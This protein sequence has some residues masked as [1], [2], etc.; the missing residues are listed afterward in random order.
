MGATLCR[1]DIR[2]KMPNSDL[3]KRRSRIQEDLVLLYLR[4]N[5]FFVSGF[6]PHSPEIG[7]TLT[8]VDALAVRMRYCAEPEREIGPDELLDLSDRFTELA[9]CEVKSWGKQIQFNAALTDDGRALTKIL[10]WSGLFVEQEIPELVSQLQ[11]QLAQR[12]LAVDAPPSIIG[13]RDAR[14]RCM[15]FSPERNKRRSNQAWFVSGDDVLEYIYRCLCP[16]HPRSACSVSYDIGVWGERE[17]MVRYFKQRATLGPGS[18]DDL[19]KALD[20]V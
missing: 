10:R 3:D 8:E 20:A 18:L 19:Y 6:V 2:P 14:I 15:F 4:L 1:D 5:G 12:P 11:Q 16:D 9:I 17:P 7:C 13:P